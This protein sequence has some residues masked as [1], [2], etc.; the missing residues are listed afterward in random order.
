MVQEWLLWVKEQDGS[1]GPVVGQRAGWF[2]RT[3]CRSEG[4]MVQ[5]LL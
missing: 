1:E 5:D 3:C 4:R 2:R